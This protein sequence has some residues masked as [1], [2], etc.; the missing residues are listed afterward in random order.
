MYL[1][2]CR[3]WSHAKV[4]EDSLLLSYP[5]RGW[6]VGWCVHSLQFWERTYCMSD[7]VLD[8]EALYSIKK[9]GITTFRK[10]TF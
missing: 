4:E 9:K 2:S 8:P 5:Q 1:L 3:N 7:T 10:P 6:M